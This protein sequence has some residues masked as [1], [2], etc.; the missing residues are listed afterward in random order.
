MRG[1]IGA[2]RGILSAVWPRADRASLTQHDVSNSNELRPSDLQGNGVGRQCDPSVFESQ[3]NGFAVADEQC[4]V[5]RP[6][7]PSVC[8]NLIKGC[9]ATWHDDGTAATSLE[10]RG[11]VTICKDDHRDFLIH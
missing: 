9:R 10:R 7:F 11:V 2:A 1:T 8:S 6:S 4:E 5:R 3:L